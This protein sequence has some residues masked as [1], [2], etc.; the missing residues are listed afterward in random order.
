MAMLLLASH[1]SSLWHLTSLPPVFTL[2][3]KSSTAAK[4]LESRD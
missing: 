2:S 4:I 1:F 3:C